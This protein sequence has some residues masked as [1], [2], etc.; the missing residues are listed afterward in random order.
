[1]GRT[2]REE[3]KEKRGSEGRGRKEFILCHRKKKE[4][5]GRIMSI[6]SLQTVV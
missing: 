4:N 2:G 1:M 5:L 6:T 3:R